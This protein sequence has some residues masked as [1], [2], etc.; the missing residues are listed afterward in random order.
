MPAARKPHRYSPTALTTFERCPRQYEFSYIE[1]P[2]I[3]EAPS[4][5]LVFGNALHEALAFLYRLPAAE[6]NEAV[7]HRALRHYWSRIERAGA[8]L[9]DNEERAWGLRALEALSDYCQHFDLGAQPLAIEEWVRAELPDGAIVYGKAD[10][11]D[12][13]ASDRGLVVIDYKSGRPP[14]DDTEL[15]EDLAARVYA[16]A[17]TRSARQPVVAVRFIYFGGAA[18]RPCSEQRWEVEAEDLAAIEDQL[19]ELSAR[20][21]STTTFAPV[22]GRHCNWCRYRHLCDADQCSLGDLDSEMNTVF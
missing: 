14:A 4:A 19:V 8:F 21:A 12:R 13:S 22:V 5:S 17:V 10:R 6:R 16:L 3:E 11:I 1:R 2:V 20:I 18:R 7:A 15:A 9:D